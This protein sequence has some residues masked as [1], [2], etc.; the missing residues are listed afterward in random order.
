MATPAELHPDLRGDEH[1]AASARDRRI[2]HFFTPQSTARASAIL[3]GYAVSIVALLGLAQVAGH[4]A[5]T[6]LAAMLIASLLKGLN[7]IVHECSHH[8]FSKDRAFNERVG[9]IL[10]VTLLSDYASYKKEHSS[11]HRFLGDYAHDLDF[12]LRQPLGHDLAFRWRRV[13]GH[14]ATFR[15]LWF[16]VPRV[17]L[18]RREHQGGVALFALVLGGLI[19]LEAYQAALAFALAHV[20]FLAFLRF[21]I[22]IVDHGGIYLADQSELYKSR[23]FILH[24]AALRWMFFPRNDCYHLIHHLYPYL[25]VASFGEVHTI[26]MEDPDYRNLRHRAT[27]HLSHR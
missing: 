21:L 6:I 5:V 3:F 12:Q 9:S 26:L 25:P 15:F 7:N 27:F 16:Y 18:T 23:N 24:N 19:V 8:S 20:V 17:R 10:C 4:P 14:L 13:L 2:K 1:R 11:H 22:D